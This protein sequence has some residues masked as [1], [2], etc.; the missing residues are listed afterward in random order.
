[1][2]RNRDSGWDFC[3]KFIWENFGSIFF[4]TKQRI[5]EN[6]QLGKKVSLNKH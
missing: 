6:G 3:F 1:M 4:R 2:N 5:I